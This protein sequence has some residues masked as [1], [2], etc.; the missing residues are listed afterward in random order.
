MIWVIYDDAGKIVGAAASED[1][2]HMAAGDSLSV[3]SHPEQI[4]IREYTVSDGVL[5]RKPDAAI[6]EQEAARRYEAADR[7]ARLERGRRLMKSDWTQ[8]PDAPVD[9]TAWAAYRQALRDITDQAGY[10][11]AITWPEVP[12]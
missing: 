3:V 8:A 6:A 4:D 2:A 1:W 5:V 10:P 11:F 12:E 9:A 7:H